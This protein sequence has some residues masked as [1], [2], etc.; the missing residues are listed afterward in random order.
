MTSTFTAPQI[1]DFTN[2][3]E[4]LIHFIDADSDSLNRRRF[5]AFWIDQGRVRGQVFHTDIA[6]FT[7]REEFDNRTARVI[8]S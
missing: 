8:E 3:T 5:A 6:Q 7:R 2:D 1:S 4:T